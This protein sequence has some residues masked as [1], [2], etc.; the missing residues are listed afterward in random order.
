MADNTENVKQVSCEK[1]SKKGDQPEQAAEAV[2]FAGEE[3]E[4]TIDSG[5]THSLE[6]ID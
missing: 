5:N 3:L 1:L 2:P 6:N 4:T